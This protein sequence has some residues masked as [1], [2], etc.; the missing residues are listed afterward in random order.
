MLTMKLKDHPLLL[1]SMVL[2]SIVAGLALAVVAFPP[3]LLP[4][5]SVITAAVVGGVVIGLVAG[6]ARRRRRRQRD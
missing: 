4:W 5:R 6:L 1:M 2:V 3:H